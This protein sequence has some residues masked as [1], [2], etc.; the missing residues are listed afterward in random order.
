MPGREITREGRLKNEASVHAYSTA[1]M[2]PEGK[3]ALNDSQVS[4]LLIS[5]AQMLEDNEHS[6][7]DTGWD[8]STESYAEYT[9]YRGPDGSYQADASEFLRLLAS[10]PD[11]IKYAPQSNTGSI[12]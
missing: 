11:L 2:H 3:R 7:Y 6:G 12:F 8:G 1:L 10:R 5:V 4:A 9:Y